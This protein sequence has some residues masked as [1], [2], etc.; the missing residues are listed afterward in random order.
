MISFGAFTRIVMV[1]VS[2]TPGI[3]SVGGPSI[4]APVHSTTPAENAHV[5][6]PGA[7]VVSLADTNTAPAGSTSI[8]VTFSA[9]FDPRFETVRVYV[10]SPPGT[11]C[12]VAP[13][14]IVKSLNAPS[15]P[16]VTV[17]VSDAWLSSSSPSGIVLSG[18]TIA[19]LVY[20]PGTSGANIRIVMV[21]DPPDPISPPTQVTTSFPPSLAPLQRNLFVPTAEMKRPPIGSE[22]RTLMPTAGSVPVFP[23]VT[24]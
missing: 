8:T 15:P 22:S 19:M 13:L 1:R 20:V 9:G 10:M 5:N 16:L 6:A 17:V 4:V 18:S 11:V 21:A 23:T 14:T 2:G 3:V 24:T 12:A 7:P